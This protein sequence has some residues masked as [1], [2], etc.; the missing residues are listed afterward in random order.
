MEQ[1]RFSGKSQWYHETQSSQNLT[2]VQP[3]V[4]EVPQVDDR[5]LLDLKLADP[6][7]LRGIPWAPI[8]R[9]L[10]NLLLP[11][12]VETNRLHTFTRYE[13]LTT[14]LTVAQVFG[15]QRLCNYYAALLAPECS[16]DSSRESNR[17]L[18]QIT[19]FSRQLAS[20]PT[21][22]KAT[23]LMELDEC[24]L[25]IEDIITFTQLIGFIGF[26]A[27]TIAVLQAFMHFPVRLLP[28]LN[29]QQ[30]ADGAIFNHP[31]GIWQSDLAALERRYAS[32][33]QLH[34]LKT[35]RKSA[36]LHE[37]AGLLAHD[38]Q[39]LMGLEQLTRQF[40]PTGLPEDDDGRL[41]MMLVSRINGSLTCF[42]SAASHW[43]GAPSL[44]DTV[45]Q[46]ESAVD[47]FSQ[48]HPRENAIMQT[49]QLLTRSP[50]RFSYTQ[51][52][53]LFAQ[54]FTEQQA[55]HLLIHSGLVGWLNRLKTGLGTLNAPK[56]FPP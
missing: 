5:F 37:L 38:P 24:G 19:Q 33:E 25:S 43:Q 34:A 26:Q 6:P 42:N 56:T 18:T 41:V 9:S 52:A 7:L 1:R 16:S 22:I 30:D 28:G 45:R 32:E 31:E 54:G 17:R 47:A 10:S 48:H 29:A 55:F 20:H 46:G 49:V 53:P 3:L 13:R 8:A 36:T 39:M 12:Q 50:D 21:S 14:A 44:P 35:G 23:S 4:P 27:Y 15:V 51:L 11:E 2:N 40:W